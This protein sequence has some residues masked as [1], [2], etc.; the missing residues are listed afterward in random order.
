MDEEHVPRVTVELISFN[1]IAAGLKP[2]L[3]AI[4]L[5]SQTAS[6]FNKVRL[7]RYDDRKRTLGLSDLLAQRQH[8]H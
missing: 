2:T 5:I 7:V 4:D 3:E 8:L 1:A 6:R